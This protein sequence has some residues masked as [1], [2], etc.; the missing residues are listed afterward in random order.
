MC[1]RVL[2]AEDSGAMRN[3]IL[4]SLRAAGVDAITEAADGD[5]AV[6]RFAAGRF[7]LVLTDW[8]MPGKTG[9][10]VVREIR[11]QDAAVKIMMIT[12][13]AEPSRVAQAIEAGVL[14]YL[15]KPFTA[16]LLREKLRKHGF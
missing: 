14:D 4:R 10:E 6:A 16:E 13:E 9:L 12:T 15:A 8:N 1:L 2:V 3:I 7:D 11:A 5:E